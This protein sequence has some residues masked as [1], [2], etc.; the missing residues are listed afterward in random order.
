MLF[1]LKGLAVL[2][3]IAVL[4]HF[5][6]QAMQQRLLYFPDLRRTTPDE[7]NL[8]GVEERE[9]EMADG[10][11]V[12]TWWGAAA[13]GRPT[14][15]YFHGNGGSFVTRSERIRKYMARGYGMVM[16]T[17][18]GYGGSS[19]VPSEKDNVADAKAVY[20]AVRAGGI[21]ADRIVLY[22]ES[23]GSG[24]AMQVAAEKP[25]AG[26]ILDAPYTAIVDLAWM[27]YP[28]LPARFLMTDRYETL[29]VAAK[30]TVP[31][32]IV[33][34]EEDSIVPVEM[35]RR[36]A[37]AI[38]GPVDLVTFPEAG[39]SDHYMYGSYDVIYAWLEKHF[40]LQVAPGAATGRP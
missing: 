32:L 29:P 36:V 25:V 34:G 26:V 10:T 16:M 28:W 23:L 31:V 21:P 2:A 39:H 7:V 20:E 6:T 8:A 27:H 3:V 40:P 30:V 24:V 11:R 13:P 4:V 38:K 19:G 1:V 18:R 37:K 22:G 17:Y 14:I 5:G 15:L 33:H 35:G 12:L 9:I